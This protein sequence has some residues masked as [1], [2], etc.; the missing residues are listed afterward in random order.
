[1]AGA[2]NRVGRTELLRVEPFGPAVRVIVQADGPAVTPHI[3]VAGE[4]KITKSKL[5]GDFIQCR[6]KIAFA[7]DFANVA[8]KRI[9]SIEHALAA[10]LS[11]ERRQ[12]FQAASRSGLVLSERSRSAVLKRG[13]KLVTERNECIGLQCV[14][15]YIRC[16]VRLAA[17]RGTVA[18]SLIATMTSALAIFKTRGFRV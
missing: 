4:G 1:V 2:V 15:N 11:E 8:D 7:L 16:R 14:C 10:G 6:D 3:G 9:D 13:G 18:M 5:A 12:R 17:K